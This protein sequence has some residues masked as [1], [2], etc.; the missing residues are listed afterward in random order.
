[1]EQAGWGHVLEQRQTGK[2]VMGR[3]RHGLR[4]SPKQGRGG[5]SHRVRRAIPRPKPSPAEPEEP[6][7][8][9]VWNSTRPR[10]IAKARRLVADPQYPSKRVLNS[11]AG[12]LAQHLG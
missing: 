2:I 12:L 9:A 11:V 10:K 6:G 8:S 1:M 4:A 3:R 7:G 5:A